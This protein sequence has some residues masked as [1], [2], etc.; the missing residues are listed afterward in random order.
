MQSRFLVFFLYISTSRGRI[1]G[2]CL[3][4]G[5]VIFWVEGVT[6]G[7]FQCGV[8]TRRSEFLQ[9]PQDVASFITFHWSTERGPGKLS[10]AFGDG[11]EH[12]ECEH[13]LHEH[14]EHEHHEHDEHDEHAQERDH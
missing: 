13:G 3:V 6:G 11:H 10:K 5:M 2:H 8:A 1:T 12:G 7:D 9:L 14:D 4:L